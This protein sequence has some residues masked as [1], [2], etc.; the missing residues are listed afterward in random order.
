MADSLTEGIVI[1]AV[2]IDKNIGLDTETC[3]YNF[4]SQYSFS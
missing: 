2:T 3:L 4:P 1:K